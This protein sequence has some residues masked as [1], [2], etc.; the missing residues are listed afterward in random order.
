[1]SVKEFCLF[2][3]R[4]YAAPFL[5]LSCLT[6]ENL[7]ESA[8]VPDIWKLQAEVA[9]VAAAELSDTL[10]TMKRQK[11]YHLTME[12]FLLFKCK[13]CDADCNSTRAYIVHRLHTTSIDTPCS[14]EKNRSKIAFTGH[15]DQA[16]GT[17]QQCSLGSSELGTQFISY[18][19]NENS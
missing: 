7:F 1:M 3:L 14:L 6:F 10:L 19:N 9:E 11:S 5:V 4:E 17:L 2:A 18:S 13:H 8:K 12:K 16:F 15:R